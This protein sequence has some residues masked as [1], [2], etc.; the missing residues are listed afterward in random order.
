LFFVQLLSQHQDA[1]SVHPWRDEENLPD[2]QCRQIWPLHRV[3][4]DA[5]LILERLDELPKLRGP[6]E[7]QSDR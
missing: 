6:A 1:R 3:Y 5:T 4:D 7:K 2:L